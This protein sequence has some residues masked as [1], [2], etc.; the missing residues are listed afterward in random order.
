M[1]LTDGEIR[2][3]GEGRYLQWRRWWHLLTGLVGIAW[4]LT[5][6]ILLLPSPAT[7]AD[8]VGVVLLGALPACIAGFW[9]F[10]R[11]GKA[12][13]RF[14]VQWKSEEDLAGLAGE[15]EPTDG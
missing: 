15:E 7:A 4:L 14:L 10:A 6:G 2:S 1:E 5:Y 8:N 3:I 11:C 12:G 13:K 9:P